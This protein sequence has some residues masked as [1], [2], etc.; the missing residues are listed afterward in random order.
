M[1]SL[2]PIFACVERGID[3]AGVKFGILVC[4]VLRGANFVRS[5]Y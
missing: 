4:L 1:L 2:E 5:E 3:F